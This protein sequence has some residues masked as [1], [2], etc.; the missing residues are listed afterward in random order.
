MAKKINY[1]VLKGKARAY[2]RD[3]DEEPHSEL[4]MDVAGVS[5]RIAINVRSNRG[6][7]ADR[8]VEYLII[9]DLQHPVVD[10]VRTLPV[11]WTS[12]E[13]AGVNG[14]A[15]DYIRSNIFRATDMKPLAHEVPGLNNDL[16]ERIEALMQRAIDD[17]QATVYAFGDRWGPKPKERDTYF[18]FKPGDGV[19][20]IHMNQGGG[21]NLGTFCDGAL[22][23]DSPGAGTIAGVFLKF[24]NQRWHTDDANARAIEGAPALPALSLPPDGLIKPWPIIAPDSPYR[25]ARIIAALVNPAADKG[26][27]FVTIL[28]ITSEILDI[29]GWTLLDQQDRPTALQ[30]KLEPGDALRVLLEG[31]QLSNE[32]GTITLL[33]AEGLKVDGV[34]YTKAQAKEK[35]QIIFFG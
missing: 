30:G 7:V 18:H 25:L 29:E 26:D 6:P 34:A 24:Q 11:G 2:T 5:F 33:N 14:G 4:L 28:N 27:E 21:E 8:L 20:M 3:D 23:I 19:H 10:K 9:D 13:N 22:F 1:G 31:S 16:F 35:G 15:I 17:S 32:G 12:L